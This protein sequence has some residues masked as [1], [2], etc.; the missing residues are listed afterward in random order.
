MARTHTCPQND[1]FPLVGYKYLHLIVLDTLYANRGGSPGAHWGGGLRVLGGQ[2][3][4]DNTGLVQNSAWELSYLTPAGAAVGFLW[5][6]RG[7][8]CLPLVVRLPPP[9]RLFPAPWL[10]L[11]LQTWH[12]LLPQELDVFLRLRQ[13]PLLPAPTP[14]HPLPRPLFKWWNGG[15]PSMTFYFYGSV[16]KREKNN[17]P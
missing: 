13:V 8:L 6:T 2:S 12:T 9:S 15:R 10:S 17:S 5:E 11:Y 14:P 16:T 1:F 3:R 4:A 7:K